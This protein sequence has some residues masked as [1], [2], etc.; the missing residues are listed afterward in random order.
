MLRYLWI[1]LCFWMVAC[2]PKVDGVKNRAILME[3]VEAEDVLTLV[4]GHTSWV[5]GIEV[6]DDGRLPSSS[7]DN[8]LRIYIRG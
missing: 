5:R 2:A 3:T 1:M 4:Q 7:Y 6:L 8:T